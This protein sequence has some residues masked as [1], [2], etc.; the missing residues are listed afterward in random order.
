MTAPRLAPVLATTFRR[1]E[2]DALLSLLRALHQGSD[3]RQI[4]RSAPIASVYGK[5]VGLRMR[6]DGAAL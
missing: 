5:F 1:D 4:A 6:A 2:V 3:A